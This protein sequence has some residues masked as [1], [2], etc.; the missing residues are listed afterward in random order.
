MKKLVS[1][2]FLFAFIVQP[3][4]ANYFK[5]LELHKYLLSLNDSLVQYASLEDVKKLVEQG[6]DVNLPTVTGGNALHIATES[7]AYLS[8]FS[9]SKEEKYKYIS[10]KYHETFKIVEFLLDKGADPSPADW[11]GL[12]PLANM[13]AYGAPNED[14][15][16]AIDLIL[17][18]K[19]DLNIMGDTYKRGILHLLSGSHRSK[20]LFRLLD[21]GLELTSITTD[22][23]AFSHL[24]S[25]VKPKKDQELLLKLLMERLP[26]KEQK[27]FAELKSKNGSTPLHLAAQTGNLAAAK[28]LI[29]TFNVNTKIKAKN[30][31]T[32]IELAQLLGKKKFVE[33][34]ESIG[35]KIRPLDTKISCHRA[36]RMDLNFEV[37]VDII[38][39]CNVKSLSKLLRLLPK[40]YLSNYVLAFFT[41]AVM[42]ASPA[43]PQV[44]TFGRDGKLLMAFNGKKGMR[45]YRNLEIIQFRDK[46]NSFELRD[47]E[48]PKT[49][50]GKVKISDSNPTK[51]LSCHGQSPRPLWDTWTFWPGKFNGEMGA[52][53][54][55]EA[56]YYQAYLKN[57]KKGRYKYLPPVDTTPIISS[58]GLLDFLFFQNNKMDIVID[59]L[60]AKK[61]I[62]EMANVDKLKPYRY[63][64][65]GSLSCQ[66]QIEDFVPTNIK[67]GFP[68]NMKFLEKDTFVKATRE[69]ETRLN[70]LEELLQTNAQGRYVLKR[71]YFGNT[72]IG[73]AGRN[74][75]VQRTAAIRFVIENAGYDMSNW[76]TPFNNGQESYVRSSF[77]DIEENAWKNILDKDNDQNLYKMFSDKNRNQKENKIKLCESLQKRSLQE[78]NNI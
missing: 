5:T 18:Y 27:Y 46:T 23:F 26:P 37:V 66:E 35:N 74:F 69:I 70:L 50:F 8:H 57:R 63:A 11:R 7:L 19:P 17:K 29:D 13:I 2:I 51:C 78:L 6:A 33:Y 67:S 60:V 73:Q 52:M 75:D 32:P 20:M 40:S 16:K 10:E 68:Y 62:H 58:Y 72:N 21:M 31:Y 9:N 65:L 28:Y 12:S 4:K 34:L 42:D 56:E 44:I 71:K 49:I 25:K 30:S 3:A 61:I 64:I 15:N 43:H 53:Y 36:N 54:P 77:A 14:F 59:D 45:G 47:I 55:R 22:G 48:F 24:A 1:I 76:F 39:T 38:K 41:N